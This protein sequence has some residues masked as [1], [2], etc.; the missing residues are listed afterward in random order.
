DI[1]AISTRSGIVLD[2]PLVPPPPPFSPSKEVERD[3]KTNMDSV[4]TESTIRIPHPVV[5]SP[6]APRSFEIPPPPI[7]SSELPKRN[8]YQP[9]IP[10]PSRLNKEKL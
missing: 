7:S 4:L 6:P 3:L 9:P 1:K 2:R 8:P 5:Q 10:Y